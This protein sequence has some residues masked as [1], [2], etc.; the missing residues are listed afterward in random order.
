MK[1]GIF[2]EA[3]LKQ[4]GGVQE[5]A[6]GL[7]KALRDK[8][9]EVYLI[10]PRG[11]QARG[12]KNLGR[13]ILIKPLARFFG[14][15]LAA[16]L[17]F[18]SFSEIKEFLRKENF[19][20]IHWQ[21]PFSLL[22]YQLL[23]SCRRQ[24]EL[25][26]VSTFHIYSQSR[27]LLFTGLFLLPSRPLVGFLDVRI[28]VSQA[29]RELAQKLFGGEY[30]IIP[31]AVDTKKFKPGLPAG[32]Q[33]SSILFVGRLDR[34]KGVMY[35]LRAFEIVKQKFPRARLVIVGQG[36]QE[37]MAKKFV[38]QSDLQ[39][40]EFAGYVSA[41]ALPR[42]YRQASICCFPA[43]GNESFGIVLLEAM[44]SAKPVVA[45][46]IEGYREVL[47]GELSRWLASLKDIE[48]LAANLLELLKKPR[49]RRRYGRLG[50][51]TAQQYSWPQ[52]SQ[53]ILKVY[54]R[55]SVVR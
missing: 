5:Y 44:A 18:A 26:K 53:Q 28:A 30:L 40:V 20:V 50:W 3:D 31:N 22:G 27:W 4:A 48:A 37:K 24:R 14:T 49:L 47:T 45:F 46:D 17:T 19:T 10:T 11:Y 16:P 1:I 9:E 39:D 6:R 32:R 34:R 51:Q 42:F 36:P 15:A 29:A 55:E 35:L 8:G 2:V 43:I 21:A 38:N 33:V 12:V 52:I 25:V 41:S 13:Q 7:V 23:W 54:Q